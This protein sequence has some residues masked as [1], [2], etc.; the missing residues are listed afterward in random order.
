MIIK[1]MITIKK[2]IELKITGLSNE[3]SPK[4]IPLFHTKIKFIYELIFIFTLP[5]SSSIDKIYNFENLSAKKKNKIIKKYII[6]FFINNLFINYFY[7]KT[8]CLSHLSSFIF[9][10]TLHFFPCALFVSIKISS[11]LS[12]LIL[13]IFAP[14][15]IHSSEK[16]IP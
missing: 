4:P 13:S 15:V 16:S 11:E 6:V 12:L 5:R 14:D 7:Y 3:N 8:P 9:Q 10:Q 1:L 2:V